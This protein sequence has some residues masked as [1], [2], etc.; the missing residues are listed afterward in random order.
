MTTTLEQTEIRRS[1]WTDRRTGA[2]GIAFAIL[3]IAGFALS[4]STPEYTA[5]DAE[6]ITW[7]EDSGNTRSAVFAVFVLMFAVVA[8]VGFVAGLA[9]RMREDSDR[10][11]ALQIVTV[12]GGAV[13]GVSMLIGGAL[14]AA[15]AGAIEFTDF[16]VPE[17][18]VLRMAE[19]LGYAVLLLG[20]GLGSF[21]LLGGVCLVSWQSDLLPRW[22]AVAGGVAGIVLL[23][24]A[25]T[26]LPVVLLPLWVIATSIVMIRSDRSLSP[27]SR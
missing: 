21:L 15:A 7:Y 19:Q 2:A 6:W 20:T 4:G 18:D 3:T 25:A 8:L 5:A 26:F 14:I 24:G 22:L 9:Q 23:V 13:L 10:P 17:A 27:G 12:I 11:D 1:G 16:P